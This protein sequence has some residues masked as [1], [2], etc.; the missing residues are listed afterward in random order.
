MV[1]MIVFTNPEANLYNVNCSC[2]YTLNTLYNSILSYDKQIW[3][4]QQ[5]EKVILAI[6]KLNSSGYLASKEHELYVQ[7][8]KERKEINKH[9]KW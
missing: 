8:I 6:E 7:D 3:T 4:Q 1:G 5:T 2:C 9:R